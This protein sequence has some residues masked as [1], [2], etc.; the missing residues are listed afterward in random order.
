MVIKG[1]PWSCDHVE[2]RVVAQQI[3]FW[4]ISEIPFWF[5]KSGIQKFRTVLTGPKLWVRFWPS[6]LYLQCHLY[7]PLIPFCSIRMWCQ[8]PWNRIFN[9]DNKGWIPVIFFCN[10]DAK[11]FDAFSILIEINTIFADFRRNFCPISGSSLKWTV[12]GQSGRSQ[13]MKADGP[14]IWK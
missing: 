5:L 12:L 10:L 11:N 1:H 6:I 2:T 4:R 9:N 13:E 3:N 7:C 8:S 14:K